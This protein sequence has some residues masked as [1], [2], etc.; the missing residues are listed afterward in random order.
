MKT[1]I[2]FFCGLF[3]ITA[4][5]MSPE[6]RK[7]LFDES[8]QTLKGTGIEKNAPQVGG[9]FP[10]SVIAGKKVTDY[11]KQGPLL[12]VVYRG[13]WCPYCVKQLKDLQANSNRLKDFKVT[14]IGIS[15]EKEAEVRKTKRKND[16]SF[17]LVSDEDGK[18]LRQLGLMFK[19]DDKVAQE[20]KNLGINLA[21]SQGN[22]RQELPVPATYLVGKDR[23]VIYG[24]IDADYRKRPGTE[25][26]FSAL[27]EMR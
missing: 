13:G 22:S 26:L 5:A 6:E 24:S 20:Y 15:P 2:L 1:L 18:L 16:L 12:I 14:I 10:D 8:I 19:V 27:K 3:A 17:T 4:A 25:E 21:E 9:T 7:K 23:K 11:V